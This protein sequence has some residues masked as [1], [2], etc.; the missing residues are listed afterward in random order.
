MKSLLVCFL[1]VTTTCCFAEKHKTLEKRVATTATQRIEI[2]GISGSNVRFKTWANNE[3]LIKLRVSISSSDDNFEEEYISSAT[4]TESNTAE[5]LRLTFDAEEQ[6]EDGGF[7]LFKLFKRFYVE[8]K[9]SGEIYV[10]QK[11][12][13]TTDIRYGTLT[14][15]DMEG[16]LNLNGVGNTVTLRRCTAI[17]NVDNNYGKTIIEHSG[18]NLKLEGTSSTVTISDFN[19]KAH[20]EADYSTVTLSRVK[21]GVYVSDKSGKVKIEDMGGN[22]TIDAD[23]SNITV[24]NV[25]G[26]VELNSTSATIKVYNVDG[27]N[28]DA[29]YSNVDITGVTGSAG[30]QIIVKGQ[31]GS[32]SLIDAVGNVL[33]DNPYSNVEL[34]NVKGNIDLTSKSASITANGVTGDWNSRTEYCSVK[35]K[36][37]D[38]GNIVITNKSDRVELRLATAPDTLSIENEYGSVNVRMPS[39][40]SGNVDLDSEYGSVHTNLS[41]KQKSRGSS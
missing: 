18:G 36:K 9:I 26:F 12:P 41:L 23:Y 38:A 31:S 5:T 29:N 14:L 7:S 32:L 30:K 15:E 33:I 21:Q 16:E 37:L 3:V 20:V 24:K 28:L 25:T 34:K 40:F 27:I 1:I 11:N 39:G 19:G 4:I 13:L 35:L 22:S 6:H 2:E 10:P 17:K 8:K